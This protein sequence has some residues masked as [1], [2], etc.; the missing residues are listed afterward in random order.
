MPAAGSP[1]VARRTRPARAEAL[2][3]RDLGLAEHREHLV[4]ARQ[5]LARRVVGHGTSGSVGH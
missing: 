3:A 1:A 4:A 2:H 5:Q